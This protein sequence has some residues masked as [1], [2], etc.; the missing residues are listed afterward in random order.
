MSVRRPFGSGETVGSGEADAEGDRVSVRGLATTTIVAMSNAATAIAT[1]ASL[2]PD[3][4]SF[5]DTRGR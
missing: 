1:G 3:H 5:M 2:I 4:R